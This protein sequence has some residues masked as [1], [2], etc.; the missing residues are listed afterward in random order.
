[1]AGGDSSWRDS[2]DVEDVCVFS[3]KVVI[4]KSGYAW[5]DDG[6]TLLGATNSVAMRRIAV[7][8][9]QPFVEQI[10][11]AIGSIVS[12]GIFRSEQGEIS[13]LLLGG[14]GGF[15]SLNKIPVSFPSN[16][17]DRALEAVQYTYTN[18]PNH[19]IESTNGKVITVF[20]YNVFSTSNGKIISIKNGISL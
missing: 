14:V 2:D 4:V 19:F 16:D 8:D 3:S 7:P 17:Q 9:Q 13:R 18:I 6:D 12:C 15:V 5:H 20:L 1:L 10:P 11:I